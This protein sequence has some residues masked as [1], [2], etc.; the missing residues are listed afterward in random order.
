MPRKSLDSRARPAPPSRA[1]KPAPP[2]AP[3]QY[4]RTRTD[5][6]QERAEDYAELID[7]LIRERGEARTVDM[8]RRLGVSHVTVTRTLS[9]LQGLGIIETEPYRSVFLTDAGRELACKSRERHRIV[10]GFLVAAGVSPEIAELDAEGIEHHVSP[11]TLAVLERLTKELER[12][13]SKGK[14]T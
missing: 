6:Q 12:S 1:A 8:A 10:L 7:D 2:E 13:R 14:Q 9:R 5:H 3:N 4:R 11:E